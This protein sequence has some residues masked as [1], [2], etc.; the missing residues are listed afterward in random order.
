[1]RSKVLRFDPSDHAGLEKS[2]NDFLAESTPYRIE[3]TSIIPPSRDGSGALATAIIFY[4]SRVEEKP[5]AVC[6]QCR[7]KPPLKGLGTCESCRD[8]QR[9]YRKKR[10]ADNKVRYP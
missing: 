5:A 9:E 10:K 2:L 6:A 3:S 4:S 1:M 7:K 8:Y